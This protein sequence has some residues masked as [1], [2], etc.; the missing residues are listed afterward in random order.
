M[1][2]LT[3]EHMARC[4]RAHSSV[5]KVEGSN[6]AVYEI[7]KGHHW[8]HGYIWKCSCK[9]FKHGGGSPCKHIK[10]LSVCEWNEY[11]DGA[12]VTDAEKCPCCGGD[13]EYFAVGV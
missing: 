3:T 2:D 13:V 1:S 6:D 4:S 7:V 12:S 10:S 8:N 9:A 5:F 11:L